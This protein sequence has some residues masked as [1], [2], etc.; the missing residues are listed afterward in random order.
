MIRLALIAV[1]AI[2]ACKQ[3]NPASCE[4]D[5]NAG[6]P[7]CNGV[8]VDVPEQC[9][10]PCGGDTPLCLDNMCVECLS[11]ANCPMQDKPL[12]DLDTHACVGCT[13]HDDCASD[14]CLPTGACAAQEDVAYVEAMATGDCSK[15]TPC[16]TLT[17]ALALTTDVVKINAN[18]MPVMEADTITLSNRA[19][20]ILAEPGAKLASTTISQIF[21]VR[22][23]GSNVGI[24]DLEIVGALA[25][26]DAFTLTNGA[27][28]LR[29]ERVT[30]RGVGGRAVDANAGEIT[31]R[32][33][34]LVSNIG[35]GIQLDAL[36]DV[37]N[38]IIAHNGNTGGTSAGVRLTPAPGS[39]FEFNTIA[40]N[41]SLA[42]TVNGV[43]CLDAMDISNSI[44]TN[45]IFQLNGVS[46]SCTFTFSLFDPPGPTG[47]GNQNAAPMF[48]TRVATQFADPG[49]FRLTTASPAKDAANP[50]A[51]ETA[52]IDSA[53]S[54]P[55]GAGR[56]IGADETD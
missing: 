51:T 28:K 45:D 38:T 11:P 12:C 44:V 32:R 56:D 26:D 21:E 34:I 16:G 17:E 37:T 3:S 14:A 20:T 19:V 25:N 43:N 2:A 29:L 35:G 50:G 55:N 10:I 40:D 47:N 53:N 30:I 23:S 42:G 13:T 33:S 54:R 6:R 15:E 24:Y 8:G 18:A 46:A 39:R 52:D 5:E 4:L 49:F 41:L 7:E 48:M 27:P 9:D 22:D 31:I 36:F 1:V